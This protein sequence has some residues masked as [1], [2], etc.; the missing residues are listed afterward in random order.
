VERL[1]LNRDQEVR[2]A[3]AEERRAQQAADVAQ[4]SLFDA[5]Q[6][7]RQAQTALEQSRATASPNGSSRIAP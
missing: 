1:H 2:I 3:F 5:R 7:L 4:T 6:R